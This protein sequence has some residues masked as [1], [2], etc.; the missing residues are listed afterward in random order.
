MEG[1]TQ[2][3]AARAPSLVLVCTAAAASLLVFDPLLQVKG[4]KVRD[5]EA[6]SDDVTL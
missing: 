3:Q 6:L 2:V 5:D 4:T 1:V